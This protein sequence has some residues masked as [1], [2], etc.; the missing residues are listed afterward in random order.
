MIKDTTVTIDKTA[1]T[2]RV[3]HEAN[4][5]LCLAHG[6]TSQVAWEDA[7]AP[8]KAS[9]IDGVR[10]AIEHPE[11]TPEDSHDNWRAFKVAEGWVYGPVKD[12]DKKTH[13]CLVE[14]DKLPAEQRAKDYVFQAIVHALATATETHN[15]HNAGFDGM[16]CLRLYCRHC[17]AIK[18]EC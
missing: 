2:A 4:R 14:Y 16:G 13:P 8:I 9:A 18:K 17:G 15:W 6:D 1:Q 10:Y 5:A 3:C 7:P 12:A 11:A